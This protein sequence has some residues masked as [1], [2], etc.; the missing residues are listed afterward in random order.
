LNQETK[1]FG[2]SKL[3]NVNNFIELGDEVVQWLLR[4]APAAA[5][6]DVSAVSLLSPIPVPHRNLLCV[7]TNY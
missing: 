6:V 5:V 4:K 3:L 7:G 2:A 1:T